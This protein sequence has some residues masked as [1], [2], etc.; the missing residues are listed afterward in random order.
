M[1]T[2]LLDLHMGRVLCVTCQGPEMKEGGGGLKVVVAEVEEVDIVEGGRNISGGG[3]FVAALLPS[4]LS[5]PLAFTGTFVPVSEC[6]P[7]GF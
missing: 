6:V 3:E 7:F 4:S 2:F 5:P 1:T